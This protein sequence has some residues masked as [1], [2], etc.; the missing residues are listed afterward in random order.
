MASTGCATAPRAAST[1]WVATSASSTHG[2]ARPPARR[3]PGPCGAVAGAHPGDGLPRHWPDCFRGR[4]RTDPAVWDH[5]GGARRRRRAHPRRRAATALPGLTWRDLVV[6]RPSAWAGRPALRREPTCWPRPANLVH[7]S[8]GQ[9]G[10][11]PRRGRPGAPA[12]GV[13][14]SWPQAGRPERR[15]RPPPWSIVGGVGDE[16]DW[17]RYLSSDTSTT[18]RPRSRSPLRYHLRPGGLPLHLSWPGGRGGARPGPLTEFRSQNATVFVLHQP[19]HEP[20]LPRTWPGAY[21]HPRS[22]NRILA[23]RIPRQHALRACLGDHSLCFFKGVVT[24]T[25]TRST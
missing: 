7:G 10:E 25:K 16:T 8:Q 20:R 2:R 17:G 9:L 12:R 13:G 3:T 21:R 6:P 22:G 4:L 5:V 23:I 19:A 1:T 11:R 18:A 15:A 14:A 24:L